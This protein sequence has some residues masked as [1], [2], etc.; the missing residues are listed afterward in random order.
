MPFAEQMLEAHDDVAETLESSGGASRAKLERHIFDGKHIVA[1]FASRLRAVP[2]VESD[3]GARAAKQL[4]AYAASALDRVRREE[5]RLRT[6]PERITPVQ[7][8]R[9]LER[10]EV[11]FFNAFA[12]LVSAPGLTAEFVPE[13]KAAFKEADSCKELEA[14]GQ[15]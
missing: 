1:R 7:S 2:A 9:S 11:T 4:E 15:D 13:F 12:E 8:A 6:L 3:A 5:R 10:I 14:I